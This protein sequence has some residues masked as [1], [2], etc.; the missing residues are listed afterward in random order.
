MLRGR[1]FASCCYSI[2]IKAT[3]D[4]NSLIL[5]VMISPFEQ[6]R[7]PREV[8]TRAKVMILKCQ[9]TWFD[10]DGSLCIMFYS[11]G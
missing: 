1:M 3:A 2:F 4:K 8:S 10:T 5:R 11:V 6:H 9:K 7:E